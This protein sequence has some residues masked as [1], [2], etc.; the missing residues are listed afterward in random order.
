M[1][2]GIHK[3]C[4]NRLGGRSNRYNRLG[5]G[6]FQRI[7][8]PYILILSVSMG[9]LAMRILAFST[10]FGWMKSGEGEGRVGEGVR[11]RE[12]G[13]ESEG[14]RKRRTVAREME[15]DSYREGGRVDMIG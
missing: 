12:G 13:D 14:W 11:V 10:R 1:W 3:Y 4:Y 5:R 8:L 6:R 7:V 2:K 15:R 9:V